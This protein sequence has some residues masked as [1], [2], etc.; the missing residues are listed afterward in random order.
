MKKEFFQKL[1]T[2][3]VLFGLSWTPSVQAEEVE[4]GGYATYV[5][6]SSEEFELAEGRPAIRIH[7][8]GSI[9]AEDTP[10]HLG[11][12]DCFAT[13]ILAAEGSP[14]TAYGYCDAT[15]RDGDLWTVWFKNEQG[16]RRTWGFL[17]G[18]G[19]YV[20]IEGEGTSKEEMQSKDRTVITWKG[21]WTLK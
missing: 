16:G 19:K 8:K 21:K 12:Q 1:L 18:T 6:V 17:G 20:G 4:G 2:G 10:F 14:L 9:I 3:V 13:I 15:D 5:T 7:Q 11:S